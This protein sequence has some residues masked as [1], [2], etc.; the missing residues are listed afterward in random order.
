MTNDMFSNNDEL[1][2]M[3]DSRFNHILSEL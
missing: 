2:E 1:W 3:I